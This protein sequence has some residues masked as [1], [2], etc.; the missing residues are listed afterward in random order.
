MALV[1]LSPDAML[2][3][4]RLTRAFATSVAL[5]MA[6][7]LA[8][9]NAEAKVLCQ[10]RSGMLALRDACARKETVVDSRQLGIEA[11][12]EQ[13]PQGAQGVPGPKGDAGPKG[14]PG[15]AGQLAAQ[16][17][18]L[19]ARLATLETLLASVIDCPFCD[20]RTV[21]VDVPERAGSIVSATST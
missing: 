16:N 1:L 19:E 21:Y 9:S 3:A 4:N 13:G 5:A 2:P 10:K 20:R 14:D 11:S 7:S 6:L 18:A 8:L 17:A 15:D 12:G